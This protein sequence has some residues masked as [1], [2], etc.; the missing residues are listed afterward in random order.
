MADSANFAGIDQKL[1]Q[2]LRVS[3]TADKEALFA[4]MQDQSGDV[5][6]AALRNPELDENHIKTLLKRRGL[7][8]S[9]LNAIY[10]SKR[11]IES[12]A[13][14][15][16]LACHP[17]T[18]S[19]I[20]LALLPLLYLF[21]LLKICFMPGT[22]PDQ[23]VGAERAIVQR[24]PTQ[25]LGNK[26]TL[27]RRGTAAVVEVLL[28]EGQPQ[29]VEACLDNPHLKEG[30]VYQFL[31]SGTASAETI[32]IVARN[33]RWKGRPNI[34]LAILKHPRTPAIWYTVLLP[35]LPHHVLRDLLATPRLTMAQKDLVRQALGAK[36]R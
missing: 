36:G 2:D 35:G 8:D 23:R 20:F 14:K 28:R 6:M 26:L 29:V 13:V 30:A 12:Y 4:I 32:S 24:L 16:A 25:P 18:P 33:S 34:K 21:D 9:L 22:T 19:H 7:S 1:S 5:L 10:T 15:F 27:A 31:T 11:L 17:E 3:L